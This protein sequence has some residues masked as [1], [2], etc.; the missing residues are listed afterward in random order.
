[1]SIQVNRNRSWTY[2]FNTIYMHIC[3]VYIYYTCTIT[4]ISCTKSHVR[5]LTEDTRIIYIKTGGMNL[6]IIL[7]LLSSW[8]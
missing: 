2:L 1:M 6:K 5:E 7:I 8:Y 3:Y 4:C